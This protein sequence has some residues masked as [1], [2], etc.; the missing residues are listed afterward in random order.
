MTAADVFQWIVLP[1]LIFG[2]RVV[3]VSLGTLRI[4]YVSRERR[5]LAAGFGF[6]EVLVWLLAMRVVFTDDSNWA[7]FIGFAAGYASGNFVGVKV[8]EVVTRGSVGLRL[9]TQKDGGPLVEH[10][11]GRG[12]SVTV[13]EGNGA[14][15][16]VDLLFV[17]VKKKDLDQLV[18][19]IKRFNPLA[20][21]TVEDIRAVSHGV[22]PGVSTTIPHAEVALRQGPP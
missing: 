15:G 11:R 1:I 10:L 18:A 16:P 22:Y 9:I 14:R 6:L 8:A 7:C 21:Y 17:V 13:V 19:D 3:D 4:L 12:L 20:F 2:T 5:W